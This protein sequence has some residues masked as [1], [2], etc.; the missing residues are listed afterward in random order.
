MW[1]NYLPGVSVLPVQHTS[2]EVKDFIETHLY[3]LHAILQLRL[4]YTYNIGI[5][6]QGL[7]PS[8]PTF[9]STDEMHNKYYTI[10]IYI[11]CNSL[12]EASAQQNSLFYFVKHAGLNFVIGPH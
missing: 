12:H 1:Q 9:L 7:F 8:F 4:I 3:K 6:C 11:A 10:T 5:S 2:C